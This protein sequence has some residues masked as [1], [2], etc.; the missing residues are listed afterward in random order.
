VERQPEV[1]LQRHVDVA[2]LPG[3]DKLNY[4]REFALDVGNTSTENK[5]KQWEDGIILRILIVQL[6]EKISE[7]GISSSGKIN[8]FVK[9]VIIHIFVENVLIVDNRLQVK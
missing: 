6:A 8:H 2:G 1:E 7:L 4:L 9:H 3:E 5:F